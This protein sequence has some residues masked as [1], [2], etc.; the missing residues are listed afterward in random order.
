MKL[1]GGLTGSRSKDFMK[2]TAL[3][4]PR[5]FSSFSFECVCDKVCVCVCDIERETRRAERESE[6]A[7][8]QSH[9][10]GERDQT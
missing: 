3:R 2:I 7:S 10:N 1:R 5:P 8:R 4:T 9:Q 6:H